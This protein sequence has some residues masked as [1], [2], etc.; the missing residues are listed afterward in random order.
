M[1]PFSVKACPVSPRSPRGAQKVMKMFGNHE[2]LAAFCQFGP[3]RAK[4]SNKAKILK[5]MYA[6]A[7]IFGQGVQGEPDCAK[8]RPKVNENARNL[9]DFTRF[10]AIWALTGPIAAPPSK[11]EG[12]L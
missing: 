5:K 12:N 9:Q 11:Y 8:R 3:S 4:F 1:R 7:A 10:L 2:I 6:Y